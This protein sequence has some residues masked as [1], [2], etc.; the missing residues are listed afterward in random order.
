M[1]ESGWSTSASQSALR[2][3]ALDPLQESVHRALMRLYDRQGRRAA[4][5]RQYQ[6]CV[7]LLQRELGTEPESETRQLYAEILR[8]RHIVVTPAAGRPAAPPIFRSAPGRAPSRGTRPFV[9][10]ARELDRILAALPAADDERGQVVLV[11]GETGIGKTRF[12]EHLGAEA[13]RRGRQIV[14]AGCHQ[15]EQM[16]P[17]RPFVDAL[18]ATGLPARRDLLDALTPRCG[19]SSRV[20]FPS[21]PNL[22]SCSRRRYRIPSGCSRRW[23][24]CSARWPPAGPW[25]WPSRI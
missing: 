25:P 18:R 16:L 7:D 5:L 8:R 12:L 3:L 10:R 24:K 22:G 9:G 20:C 13:E 15:T 19:P 4:S 2:L 21:S 14:F 1:P 23:P 17:L 11:L 6:E